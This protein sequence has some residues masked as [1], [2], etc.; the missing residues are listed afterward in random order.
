MMSEQAER[1]ERWARD[2][3]VIHDPPVDVPAAAGEG[4]PGQLPRLQ[5]PGNGVELRTF[6]RR[7]GEI[8]KTKEVYRRDRVLVRANHK[9]LRM[10]PITPHALRTVAEEWVAFYA[11]RQTIQGVFQIASSMTLDV[12]TA[13]VQAPVFLDQIPEVARI[14]PVRQPVFRSNGVLALLP[15]GYDAESRVFTFRSGIAYDEAIGFGDAVRY[16][17]DLLGEFPFADVCAQTGQSRSKAVTLAGML[18]M[19]AG[20]MLPGNVLRPVLVYTSN[21]QRSGKSLLAK[22]ALVPLFGTFAPQAWSDNKEEMRKTLDSEAL[23]ASPYIIFDNL[24]G[25]VHNAALESFL[26]APSWKGRVLGSNQM[27]QADNITSVFLTGNQ[28][29]VSTDIAGRSLWVELW[30]DQADPQERRVRR[31]ID[32]EWLVV[33]KNRREILSA[34]WAI[35]REWDARGR[36]AGVGGLVGYGAWCRLIGGIAREVGWG[37]PL[38]AP[39]LDIAGD[40]QL[41]DMTDLA[42]H[43][44]GE[45]QTCEYAFGEIVSIARE[46]NLFG[47]IIPEED[48]DL[49]PREKSVLGKMLRSYEGRIFHKGDVKVR[50]GQRG[51]K[52]TRRYSVTRL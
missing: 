21:S 7:L 24:K 52:R 16:L 20:G 40:N 8:L 2:R 30:V 48:D 15:E 13:V 10:D 50:F 12:A 17:D 42:V 29:S 49:K 1:L 18:S 3:G 46:N 25:H 35:V 32:E 38:H 39:K 37:D 47:W 36:P 19:F 22:L 43:L 9:A 33:P 23:S 14:N 11:E 31:E 45:S 4:G 28:L 41:E 26:T 34:M 27:F 44:L 51:R 6:A 5:L